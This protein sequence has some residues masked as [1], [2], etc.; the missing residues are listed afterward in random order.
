MPWDF[1][2]YRAFLLAFVSHLRESDR[3]FS[4]RKLALKAGFRTPNYLRL[5]AD[6]T[7]S[8][9]PEGAS[10]FARALGLGAKEHEAFETLVLLD[11]ARNDEDRN[12]HL[13][14]LRRFAGKGAARQLTQYDLYSTWY[15]VPIREMVSLS[16]FSTDPTWI[17]KRIHPP[18]T[19]AQAEAALELL[20]GAGL[21]ERTRGGKIRRTDAHVATPPTVASLA[22]RN[23]HRAM[24][25][26]AKA[27]LERL[28]TSARH[29]SGVTLTLSA[30]Q[31]AALCRRIDEF[32]NEVLHAFD[33]KGTPRG[34]A[35]EVFHM[36]LQVIPVT[37]KE[38][39]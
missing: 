17:A 1:V 13:A 2:D 23:F 6:G 22:V 32:R 3:H 20:L 11:R 39:K 30:E 28:P 36:G 7:R 9:S 27:S 24:L 38:P 33:T 16:D 8:L 19:P 29:V 12:R 25:E 5:V 35:R 31:Y 15:A 4:Y 18:I 14:R 26:H 21:L 10:R 37:R 34:E